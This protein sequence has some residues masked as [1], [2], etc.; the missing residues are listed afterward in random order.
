MIFMG[1]FQ[2]IFNPLMALLFY[3][4]NPFLYVWIISHFHSLAVMLLISVFLQ[5]ENMDVWVFRLQCG[6]KPD[7]TPPHSPSENTVNI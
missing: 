5:Q 7:I 2:G 6:W 4:C 1:F 3:F